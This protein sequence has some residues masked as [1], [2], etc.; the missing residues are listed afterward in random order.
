MVSTPRR[1]V[2]TFVLLGVG[3]VLVQNS[4]FSVTSGVSQVPS[5]W[6]AEALDSEVVKG[7]T[8]TVRIENNAGANGFEIEDSSG[9]TVYFEPD[10][11]FVQQDPWNMPETYTFELPT[12]NLPAGSN[13]LYVKDVF[14]TYNFDVNRYQCN[15][16]ELYDTISFTVQVD[17][18]GDGFLDSNDACPSTGDQGFGV[19]DSGCPLED[20]DNDG[21]LDRNDNCPDT[22]GSKSDGCPSFFEGILHWFDENLGT[23]LIS[24]GDSQ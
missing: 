20:N 2:L 17:S 3:V 16:Q 10:N 19:D 7:E 23:S 11:V 24:G 1:L 13:T 22:F 4:V 6:S 15:N 8:V 21:V 14:C 9:S 12:D 18:D 5:A